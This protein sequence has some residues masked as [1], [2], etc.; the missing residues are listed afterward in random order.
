M[1]IATTVKSGEQI[2]HSRVS[3]LGCKTL[4]MKMWC[5]LP[6]EY[7]I[8]PSF[9]NETPFRVTFYQDMFGLFAFP[10]T[11]DMKTETKL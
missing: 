10:Q 3:M 6:H 2:S 1:L 11:E 7:V 8:G 9:L 5:R 4:N